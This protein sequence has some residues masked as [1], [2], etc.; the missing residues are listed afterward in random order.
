FFV[1]AFTAQWHMAA[2]LLR[3]VRGRYSPRLMSALRATMM[4]AILLLAAGYLLGFTEL[5][6]LLPITSSELGLF[7]GVAQMWL[8]TSSCGYG[9]HL[10][11]RWLTRRIPFN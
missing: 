2:T 8:L 4:V 6:A 11:M 7:S 9:L 3:A 5:R 10:L 1:L